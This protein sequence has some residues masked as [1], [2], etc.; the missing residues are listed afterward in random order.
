[1]RSVRLSLTT[2]GCTSAAHP[3]LRAGAPALAGAGTIGRSAVFG[4]Y[5]GRQRKG[6]EAAT[7]AERSPIGLGEVWCGTAPRKERGA[8]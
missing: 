1:M 8:V 2:G 7:A 4:T 5:Y 6:S 3:G